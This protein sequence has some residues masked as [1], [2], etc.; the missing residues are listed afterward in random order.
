[1]NIKHIR[2]ILMLLAI[3][4]NKCCYAQDTLFKNIVSSQVKFYKERA[5]DTFII[6][7]L[8][9]TY[10]SSILKNKVQSISFYYKLSDIY[11]RDIILYKRGKKRIFK[12]S[13]TSVHYKS[14][15]EFIDNNF[16]NSVGQIDT[17]S[18]MSRRY[19][20]V[21]GNLMFSEIIES[22]LRVKYYLGISING[23]LFDDNIV[24]ENFI[25]TNNLYNGFYY[26]WVIYSM[27]NN[28]NLGLYHNTTSTSFD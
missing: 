16:N 20:I 5:I 15:F 2:Y 22:P 9:Q 4:I 12:S 28:Y 25:F 3:T 26:Y 17:I 6:S 13:D 27:L 1:M 10:Y 14:L 7:G 19:S 11:V 21:D 8:N 23:R 24:I 18:R